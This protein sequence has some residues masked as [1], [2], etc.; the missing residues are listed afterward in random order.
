[1]TAPR[2]LMALQSDQKENLAE[3]GFSW[4]TSGRRE[5]ALTTGR[6]SQARISRLDPVV[7][8]GLTLARLWHHGREGCW[9]EVRSIPGVSHA[10]YSWRAVRAASGIPRERREVGLPNFRW[11]DLRHFC[12]TQLLELGSTISRSPSSLVT[13][14]AGP[15]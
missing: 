8:G 7:T 4:G 9:A 12:A 13:R 1:M 2:A 11:H 3:A 5:L 6:G 15:S 14:T 10:V